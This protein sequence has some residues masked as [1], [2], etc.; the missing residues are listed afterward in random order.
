MANRIIRC[1][2]ATFGGTTIDGV[3]GVEFE[4]SIVERLGRSDAELA[5]S[6]LDK[7]G[8]DLRGALLVTDED[9]DLTFDNGATGV[10]VVTYKVEGGATRTLTI[11]LAADSSGVVFDEFEFTVDSES[12]EPI[13]TRAP[14]TAV[15]GASNTKTF[16]SASDVSNSV[17]LASI[18]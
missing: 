11:G 8:R 14:F 4:E 12:T 6:T 1:T 2:G 13:V 3:Y 17:A 7:I 5:I 9:F 16:G 10:L 18:A 15:Y